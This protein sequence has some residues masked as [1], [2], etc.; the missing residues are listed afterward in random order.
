MVNIL[1]FIYVTNGL[2][3]PWSEYNI[4]FAT[5]IRINGYKIK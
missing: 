2:V 5:L 3:F 4:I 1:L